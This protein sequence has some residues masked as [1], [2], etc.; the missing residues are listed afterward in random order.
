[1]F[2][3]APY[4]DFIFGP[5]NI[6]LLQHDCRRLKAELF[7]DNQELA[8]RELAARSQ[9]LIKAWVSIMYGC[10]NF[11]RYCIVPYTRGRECIQAQQQHYLRGRELAGKGYKEITLLGQNVNSYRSDVDFPDLLRKID[12]IKIDR[13]RFVTSHPRDFS[14]RLIVQWLNCPSVRTYTSADSVRVRHDIETYE[15]GIH[16]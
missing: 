2:R 12:A 14:E 7:D 3:R 8:L 10:N 13:I 4:V 16:L 5:Q 11:C 9:S 6:H 15:Q 1:M